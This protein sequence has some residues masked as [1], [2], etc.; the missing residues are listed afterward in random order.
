M[1]NLTDLR[2]I[3]ITSKS[4][5]REERECRMEEYLEMRVILAVSMKTRLIP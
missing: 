2:V 1:N 3:T 5:K 4:S